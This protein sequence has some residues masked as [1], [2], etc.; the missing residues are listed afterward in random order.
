MK[1]RVTP[2]RSGV[3]YVPVL[4][5]WA[6]L[7]LFLWMFLAA[8]SLERTAEAG[9][10]LSTDLSGATA[11]A[12]RYSY[13]WRHGMAGGWPLY[14]PGFF[15]VAIATVI[16]SRGR[17]IRRLFVEGSV[18][19]LLSLLAAKLLA[20]VGAR[21]LIASFE[22][23]TGLVL[24]GSP[25]GAAWSGALPCAITVISWVA[26]MVAIQASVT[27]RSIWPLLA[28]LACYSALVVIRPGDF[29][30]LMRPWALAVGRLEAVAIFSTA[31]IPLVATV[32]ALYCLHLGAVRRDA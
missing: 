25:V 13:D 14:T 26:L 2:L 15:A 1:H 3:R 7:F 27:G 9:R 11:L 6:A 20:P 8:N 30:E 5:L 18:A 17:T 10:F 4:F 31:L 23:D 19:L 28:P 29:G 16:W 32:L 24:A 21:W 22:V 12:E